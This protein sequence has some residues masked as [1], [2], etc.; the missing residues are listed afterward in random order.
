MAAED[1]LKGEGRAVKVTGP[2]TN[3]GTTPDRSASGSMI[4][5]SAYLRRVRANIGLLT[6]PA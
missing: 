6:D 3:S 4:P 2:L 1:I 5:L